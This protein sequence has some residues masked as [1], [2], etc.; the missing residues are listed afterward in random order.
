MNDERYD[1]GGGS[2][3]AIAFLAG[4]AVGAGVALLFAPKSGAETRADLA[5]QAR[6][7]RRAAGHLAV[8]VREKAME[9]YDTTRTEARRRMGEARKGVAS[10]LGDVKARVDAGRE[11]GIAGAK[12]AREEY[13]RRFADMRAE[14]DMRG[15]T[16]EG[17][18][19]D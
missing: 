8:N 12:A 1:S 4:L 5:R 14:T 7:A 13:G 11:A 18:G 19:A 17:N 16:E 6:K 2:R 9:A 10:A 15:E 3:A